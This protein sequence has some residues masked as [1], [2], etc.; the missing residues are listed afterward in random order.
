MYRYKIILNPQ[1]AK[2]ATRKRIPEIRQALNQLDLNYSLT[3]T[4]RPWHAAE[5]AREAVVDGDEN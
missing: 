5:L 4:E 2:G 3:L 1:S